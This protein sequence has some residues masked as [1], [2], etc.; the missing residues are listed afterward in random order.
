MLSGP[1]RKMTDPTTGGAAPDAALTGPAVTT[2]AALLVRM[3]AIDAALPPVDGLACFNRMYRQITGLVL[4]QIGAGFFTD[5]AY[6]DRLDVVFGN[7]YL[8][9]VNASVTQPDQVASC[10]SA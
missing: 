9:A 5:Q 1:A 2:I 7:L 3:S 10:W 8:A 4:G 6:M